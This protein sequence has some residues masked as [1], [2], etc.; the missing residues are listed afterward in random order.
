MARK[1]LRLPVNTFLLRKNLPIVLTIELG[2]EDGQLA[3]YLR[4]MN[5]MCVFQMA[6]YPLM[7]PDQSIAVYMEEHV[8][9]VAALGSLHS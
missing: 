4:K 1:T 5:I 2:I 8:S 6:P 9:W 3:Y 7:G